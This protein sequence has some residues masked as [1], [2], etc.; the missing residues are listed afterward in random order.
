MTALIPMLDGLTFAATRERIEHKVKTQEYHLVRLW[1]TLGF[2]IPAAVL[3][4]LLRGDGSTNATA[5]Y[6]GVMIA[7]AGPLLAG[8]LPG[9]APEKKK[10]RA[11]AP[12]LAAVRVLWKPHLRVMVACMFLFAMAEGIRWPFYSQYLIQLEIADEW[13]GVIVNIG[14]AV[15]V[16]FILALGPLLRTLGVRGVLLM[17]GVSVVLR[18]ALLA[19]VPSIPVVIATQVLHGPMVLC[20][21]LVPPMYLNRFA[22]PEFRN[23]IQGMYWVVCGGIARIIGSPLGG[24]FAEVD[25][26][27]AFGLGTALCSVGLI[28]LFVGFHEPDDCPSEA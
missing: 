26:R 4:F 18:H 3:F 16:V 7:C 11:E 8:L 5:I 27:A 13:V 22:E 23:S 15:E 19:T 6:L 9:I 20:M 10:P 2:M 24:H 25:L 28:V 14:V 21:F 17:G 1:G 12:T